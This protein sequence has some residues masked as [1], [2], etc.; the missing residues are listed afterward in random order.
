MSVRKT[1][2]HSTVC[3][4]LG[5]GMMT[6]REDSR[7]LSIMAKKTVVR[8]TLGFSSPSTNLLQAL[9]LEA[10]A[11]TAT[12]QQTTWLQ[13]QSEAAALRL[14][15]T[16]P[17]WHTSS[18]PARGTQEAVHQADAQRITATAYTMPRAWSLT[19]SPGG[20]FLHRGRTQGGLVVLH[21]WLLSSLSHAMPCYSQEQC[22]GNA[23]GRQASSVKGAGKR[24]LSRGGGSVE[25]EVVFHEVVISL[26]QKQPLGNIFAPRHPTLLVEQDL[27]RERH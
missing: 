22:R 7:S 11:I 19:R 2:F 17:E 26:S 18:V 5:F 14:Q 8:L 6:V 23:G 25:R 9:G 10:I 4:R 13:G 21:R 1:N 3:S 15:S 12:K 16:A 27:S 20:S 24:V